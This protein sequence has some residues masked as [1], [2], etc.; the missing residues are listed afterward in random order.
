MKPQVPSKNTDTLRLIVMSLD[1]L[2]IACRIQTVYKVVNQP[3]I[4]SSG[5][6]YTGLAHIDGHEVTVLD[7][8]RRLFQVSA[9]DKCGYL[10]VLTLTTGE[11]VA[12][13]VA[14]SPNLMD[15][16]RKHIRILP[17]CYRRNDTLDIASH[18]AV[19]PHGEENLTIFLLDENALTRV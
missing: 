6:S 19:V 17:E 11:F 10:V 3:Q 2:T 9:T 7:L 8:H 18:V 1:K 15:I 4:H 16:P 5:L 12:I 13:S 14:K